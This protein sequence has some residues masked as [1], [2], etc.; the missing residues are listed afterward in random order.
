MRCRT[1]DGSTWTTVRVTE[2]RERLG[3]APY[4]PRD[5]PE[6]TVSADMAASRLGICVGS[7]HRLIRQGVLPAT[8]LMPSAPWKIPVEALS[9]DAVTI[10]VREI[11]TRRPKNFI[12]YQRDEAMRL[13]GL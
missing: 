11:K 3:I 10:G 13:P 5:H 7:V 6:P 1:Q 2:L 12:D 8:Q 9:S 4:D